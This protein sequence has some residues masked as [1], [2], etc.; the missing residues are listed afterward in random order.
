MEQRVS[1]ITLA[2][3]DL[4]KSVGFYE[5]MGFKLA[6]FGDENF[7]TFQLNGLILGLYPEDHLMKDAGF[8]EMKPKGSYGGIALAHNVR[9]KEDVDAF[10]ADAVAAGGTITRPAEEQ[11]WGGYSG[12]FT[13]LDGHGWEV[14]WNPHWPIDDDG[15]IFLPG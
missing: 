8:S 12:Y 10:L 1:V 6:P 7:K 9:A 2:V 4:A 13:D 3:E 5:A 15:N 11:F 14:A